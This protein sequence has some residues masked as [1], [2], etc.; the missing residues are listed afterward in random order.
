MGLASGCHALTV[1][2]C[3]LELGLAKTTPVVSLHSI[4]VVHEI[5]HDSR[6]KF[7]SARDLFTHNS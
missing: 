3:L 1:V 6:F 2:S 4:V 5:F 7:E